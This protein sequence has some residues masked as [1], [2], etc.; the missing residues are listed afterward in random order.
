MNG[1]TAYKCLECGHYTISR[2]DGNKCAKCDGPIA[3]MGHATNAD[4]SKA[5]QVNVSI[6][7]TDL[8]K[9]MLQIFSAL[10]DDERT[11]DWA[12]EKI[13]RHV[14]NAVNK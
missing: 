8:F 12:K 4:A 5:L 11:P 9:K 3:P 2:R 13:Q 1:L 14:L 7:D 6:K 10:I